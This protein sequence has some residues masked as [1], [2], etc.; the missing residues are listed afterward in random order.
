MSKE[1]FTVQIYDT[2]VTEA[3]Y[4][5]KTIGEV[6]VSMNMEIY[7]QLAIAIRDNFPGRHLQFWSS[8]P[9]TATATLTK[10]EYP[11]CIDGQFGCKC[12]TSF[13]G[14]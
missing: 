9:L 3:P 10:E 13:R 4:K 1:T 8:N 12:N 14:K 6:E 11:D 5:F 2:S 7:W